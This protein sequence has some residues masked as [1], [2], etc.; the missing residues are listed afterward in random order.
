[1]NYQPLFQ[2]ELPAVNKFCLFRFGK[3]A[4]RK[5]FAGTNSRPTERENRSYE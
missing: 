5:F 1:V 4:R 2:P 3:I